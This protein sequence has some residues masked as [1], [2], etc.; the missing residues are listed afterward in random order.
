MAKE[1]EKAA[2]EPPKP[3]SIYTRKEKWFIVSLI[4]LAGL[5]R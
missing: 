5:F 4:A 1:Q 3:Y 2:I